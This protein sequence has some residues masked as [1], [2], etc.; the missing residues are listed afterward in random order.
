MSSVGDEIAVWEGLPGR[1]LGDPCRFVDRVTRED[2]RRG[3]ERCR[4]I[5]AVGED[6]GC[7]GDRRAVEASTQVAHRTGRSIESAANR[8]G[9]R[10]RKVSAMSRGA[11]AGAVVGPGFQ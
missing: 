8:V 9:Q 10:L 6:V 4:E 11:G 1:D 2:R 5:T 3:V 7:C